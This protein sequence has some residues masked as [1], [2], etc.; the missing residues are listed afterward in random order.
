MGYLTNLLSVLQ[1]SDLQQ[2]DDEDFYDIL[3]SA[4]YLFL[5]HNNLREKFVLAVADRVFSIYGKNSY[6][7]HLLIHIRSFYKI[8]YN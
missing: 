4:R 3:I 2:L 7:F 8:Q 1:S 6:N 5:L